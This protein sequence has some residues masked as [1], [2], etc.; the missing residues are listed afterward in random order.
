MADLS[1]QGNMLERARLMGATEAEEIIAA[2][3]ARRAL[4]LVAVAVAQQVG[5][6]SGDVAAAAA[7]KALGCAD[8][9]N[10]TYLRSRDARAAYDEGR[11]DFEELCE[12]V[13]EHRR[14]A[15]RLRVDVVS[16]AAEPLDA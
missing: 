10:L 7:T 12:R 2:D 13:T 5:Q 8:Q 1:H 4:R 16:W 11:A 9:A 3:Y 6:Q 14:S 15:H